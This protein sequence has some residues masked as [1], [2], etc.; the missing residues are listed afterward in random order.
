MTQKEFCETK[1]FVSFGF[2]PLLDV[3]KGG[4]YTALCKA[5]A[6]DHKEYD[7]FIDENYHFYCYP[8]IPNRK[9]VAL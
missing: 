2:V 1:H 9:G 3:K 6:H 4:R 7:I 8:V 5:F